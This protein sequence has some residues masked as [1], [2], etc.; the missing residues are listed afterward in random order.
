MGAVV[1]QVFHGGAEFGGGIQLKMA[2]D[3]G[4]QAERFRSVLTEPAGIDDDALPWHTPRPVAGFSRVSFPSQR[5]LMS[6]AFMGYQH[7]V[8]PRA[9]R[10][11]LAGGAWVWSGLPQAITSR[12]KNSVLLF[13]W[14]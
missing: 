13:G 8:A 11:W 4:C 12:Q 7:G 3:E 1:A 9:I 6:P 14:A 2:T 5:F 10:F